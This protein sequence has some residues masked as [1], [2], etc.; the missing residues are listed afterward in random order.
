MGGLVEEQRT[1]TK[2]KVPLLGDI[3]VIGWFFKGRSSDRDK[4]NLMIF[5]R[6]TIFREPDAANKEAVNRYVQ[7]RLDQL[8]N[9]KSV[10][11]LLAEEERTMLL[12]TLNKERQL[13]RDAKRGTKSKAKRDQRRKPRKKRKP[14]RPSGNN[15]S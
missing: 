12:P 5:I 15:P 13:R 11:S 10:D 14:R 1:D 7:L 4:T 8:E 9:L 6:P 2:N 3:P